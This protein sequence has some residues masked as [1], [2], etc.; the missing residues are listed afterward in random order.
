MRFF[1]FLFFLFFINYP[2]QNP[3]PFLYFLFPVFMWEIQSLQKS[4]KKITFIIKGKQEAL[5]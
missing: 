4:K 5:I 2:I 1:Y 3:I